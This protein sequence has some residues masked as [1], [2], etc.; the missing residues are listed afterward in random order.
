ML[1]VIR[2]KVVEGKVWDNQHPQCYKANEN[3]TV[4]V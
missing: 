4:F 2:E 3:K 1:L